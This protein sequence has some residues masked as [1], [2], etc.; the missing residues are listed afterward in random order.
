MLQVGLTGGI[1]SGKS[2]VSGRLAE[3]GAVV[4]DADRLAREVV[5]PGT[6]GLAEVGRRFGPEVLA[7]DG[8]LDRA[9]LGA[10][11]FSHPAARADLE[12]ITHPLVRARTAE[13]VA[14]APTDAVVVHDVPLLVEKHLGPAYHLVVVV[15]A[16]EVTRVSRLVSAR[17]LTEADARARI[18]AQADDDQRRAAADVWLDNEGT[19]PQL[20]AQVDALWRDRL[21]PF[22]DN[23]LHGRRP[24]RPEVPTLVRYDRSWPAQGGRLTQRL[25]RALGQ[26][27]VRVDHIGSTSVPGLL[28]KDVIDLQVGV[29]DLADA[30]DPAFV[31]AL[32]DLGFP[33]SEGNVQDT[34]HA[35]APDP[36]DWQK[37]FHGSADPGRVAHLHVRRVGSP[38]HEVALLFRDWLRTHPQEVDAYAD[39]KRE[40]AATR[41]T[42]T[43]YTE[44]KE[45]WLARALGRARVWAGET[46]WMA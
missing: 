14:Q 43:D 46:Q 16:D 6:P 28:A 13:L 45:P 1:G 20:L 4:V 40:L 27:A 9:A 30:D 22:N 39:L 34:V 11:V 41:S 10:L 33:R 36:V 42:T 44:A 3:L 37:R 5:A 24:P 26:R 38:G 21:V 2:T 23:L 18:A 12:Q 25:E 19:P 32:R 7:A 15:H 29:R 35:W 17:G 31:R 8:A